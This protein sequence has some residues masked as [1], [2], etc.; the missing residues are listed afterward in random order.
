MSKSKY[1]PV[2]MYHPRIKENYPIQRMRVYAQT[3]MGMDGKLHPENGEGLREDATIAFSLS[4]LDAWDYARRAG[5]G[6]NGQWAS[7]WV[8]L[9]KDGSYVKTEYDEDYVRN[10]SVIDKNFKGYV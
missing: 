10:N 2:A 8:L 3:G 5:L 7:E 9:N 6:R 4:A 1:P